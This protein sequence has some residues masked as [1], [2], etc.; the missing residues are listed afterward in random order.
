MLLNQIFG[1]IKTKK[2]QIN[3]KHKNVKPNPIL[4]IIYINQSK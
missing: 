4:Y 1:I 2:F 3:Q